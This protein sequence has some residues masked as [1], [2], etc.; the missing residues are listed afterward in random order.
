M[1]PVTEAPRGVRVTRRGSVALTGYRENARQTPAELEIRA[2][3]I[4]A[5]GFILIFFAVAWNAIISLVFVGGGQVQ[6]F[7]GL[8]F[9]AGIFLCYL[10]IKQL[11]NG[12]VLK[13]D[14]ATLATKQQTNTHSREQRIPV[15]DI[16]GVFCEAGTIELGIVNDQP[17]L[18]NVQHVCARLADG[19]VARVIG[20]IERPEVAFFVA[21]LLE[22]E[23]REAPR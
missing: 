9:A 15:A 6:W 19:R 4:G 10:A 16:V 7:M 2:R 3:S 21:Q 14:A 17:V 5:R 22:R 1:I 23:I 13:L 20:E 12:F 8:H 11:R 18:R